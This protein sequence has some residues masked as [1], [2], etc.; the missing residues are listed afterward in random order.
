MNVCLWNILIPA[1]YENSDYD[2]SDS[3]YEQETAPEQS[4]H[5][6]V[7]VHFGERMGVVFPMLVL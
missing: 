1:D 3:D 2:N 6:P 4:V 7:A 5:S